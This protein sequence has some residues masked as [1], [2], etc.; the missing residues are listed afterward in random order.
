[1]MIFVEIYLLQMGDRNNGYEEFLSD[2][3]QKDGD[4]ED[5]RYGLYDYEYK[6]RRLL[7]FFFHFYYGILG[8]YPACYSY[9]WRPIWSGSL[10]PFRVHA[11]FP[12]DCTFS[13]FLVTD[14]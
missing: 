13:E 12:S 8:W 14:R 1:M 11:S 9:K 3:Q 10:L 2:L 4:S 6:V 5:C 7:F